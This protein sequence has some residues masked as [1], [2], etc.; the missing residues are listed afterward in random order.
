MSERECERVRV[1]KR[2]E[3]KK[4]E[5]EIPSVSKSFI[6]PNTFLDVSIASLNI[7]SGISFLNLTFK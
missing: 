6:P 1:K 5:E 7:S 3:E 2:E 4:I